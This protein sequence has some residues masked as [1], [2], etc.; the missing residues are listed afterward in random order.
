MKTIVLCFI[1]LAISTPL[2]AADQIKVE[3]RFLESDSPIPHDLTKINQMQ[4]VELLAAPSVTTNSGQQATISVTHDFSPAS[5]TSSSFPP[6]PAGASIQVTP[7]IKEG[8]LFYNAE[9]TL[10]ELVRVKNETDQ[11]LSETTS[12]ELYISGS[13]ADGELVWIDLSDT[14]DGKKRI[15]CLRFTR[16]NA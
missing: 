7:E 2:F 8:R 11:K 12:R 5:V 15:V 4:G 9:V 10:R 13:P 16:Q 1:V 3:T 6:V 14:L